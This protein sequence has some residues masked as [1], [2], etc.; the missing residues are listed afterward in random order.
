MKKIY[1]QL[2]SA[3]AAGQEQRCAKKWSCKWLVPGLLLPAV[4][5]FCW[6]FVCPAVLG[7]VS[8]VPGKAAEAKTSHIDN[9]HLQIAA[10]DSIL[11]GQLEQ[12]GSLAAKTLEYRHLRKMTPSP[13]LS[14]RIFDEYFRRL[15]PGKVYFT[16]QDVAR[17]GKARFRLLDMINN[18]EQQVIFDIYLCYL[19]RLKQYRKFVEESVE[20]GMSFD[21]NETYLADRKDEDYC[22]DEQELQQLWHKR[23]KNDLLYYRLMQRVMEE[24]SDDPEVKA[25]LKKRWFKKTPGEKVKTR[26]HDLYNFAVQADKMDV[27][28][29]FLTAMAQVYGPHSHYATPKQEEDF[30]IQFKLSLSG[31]GA[32]LSS[33]DGYTKVVDLVPGGPADKD[34]RLQPEDRIIAVAQENG[35]PVDVIDMSVNNVVKLVRGPAGS[36][37]TLSVLPAAKGAAALPVDITI[38]RGTVELKENA[39]SG[40]VRKVKAAD[41]SLRRIG[42]IKLNSFYMDF[43]GAAR[44]KPNYRSCTRDVRKIL[45]DFN[46]AGVDGVVLDLRSN[47]GGSLPEAVSLSGLFIRRGPVVQVVD[48]SERREVLSDQDSRL[49]YA[50]P[51]V[52][53][54]SKFTASS[55]EILSGAM[56]DYRR[57]LIVGDSRTYGKG[58]VLSVT[59]LSRLLRL[60]NRK[61]DAGSLTHEIAMFYRVNG[62]SNQARGIVPDVVLPS[63]T[64]VMEIGEQ[65]NENHLPW[66]KIKSLPV[67]SFQAEG[68]KPVSPAAVKVLADN[69]RRRFEDN[70]ELRRLRHEIERFK[71]IRDR[72]EVS[73]N[74]KQRLKEYYDEKAASEKIDELMQESDKKN[75]QKQKKDLLLDE[76]LTIACE[77]ID[78]LNG[79]R[80]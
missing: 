26:M 13:A 34:G 69:S 11:P 74:E 19:Q 1:N 54:V 70:A 58:T 23:L 10:N 37:V 49:D 66:G 50:G 72:R 60:F 75:S 63:F 12:V 21:G 25:D 59:D 76:T 18:G 28:G 40:E 46:A 6:C 80:K 30:N 16:K 38:V 24:R 42:V 41:G 47:S 53:L 15:D 45:H 14:G 71:V 79:G 67:E 51:L 22:R 48:A 31:I 27:L 4:A 17:F 55:S 56:Q 29:I 77:Y 73:L 39:A 61:L 65:Y 9:D 5:V 36:K 2:V 8:A 3:D 43:E 7:K 68:Y 44:G 32:T 35:E 57:A 64:E 20:K 52:V 33:E 78:I 62:E